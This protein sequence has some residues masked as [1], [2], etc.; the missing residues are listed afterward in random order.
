MVP[1]RVKLAWEWNIGFGDFG[2]RYYNTWYFGKM[3]AAF[4]GS[5]AGMVNFIAGLCIR[6]FRNWQRNSTAEV[7]S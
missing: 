6:L 2:L 4:Y 3:A 1:S 7:S 5:V